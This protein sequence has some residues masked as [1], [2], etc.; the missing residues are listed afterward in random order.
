MRSGIKLALKI[1][2][3]GSFA[4]NHGSLLLLHR[5]RDNRLMEVPPGKRNV[6]LLKKRAVMNLNSCWSAC[7][8]RGSFH[9]QVGI[10]RKTNIM[11]K[12]LQ[13]REERNNREYLWRRS[14]RE[15]GF[16]FE[17]NEGFVKP[18]ILISIECSCR[19]R[20]S[21]AATPQQFTV[22]GET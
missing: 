18:Y 21:F 15:N 14:S 12:T 11:Q 7:S 5:A 20:S 4:S 19:S 8:S 17:G 10:K 2:K 1:T 16:Y 3:N 6:E 13:G 22:S 9:V